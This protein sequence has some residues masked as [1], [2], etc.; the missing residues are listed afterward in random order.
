[1]LCD[2]LLLRQIR[3]FVLCPQDCVQSS[4]FECFFAEPSLGE[5]MRIC[6]ATAKKRDRKTLIFCCQVS[7][8]LLTMYTLTCTG[9]W[10]LKSIP[11]VFCSSRRITRPQLHLDDHEE[12]IEV[13]TAL[14]YSTLFVWSMLVCALLGYRMYSNLMLQLHT[15]AL[16][17]SLG[18]W[19]TAGLKVVFN[20]VEHL[21][22]K[23]YASKLSSLCGLKY[24]TDVSSHDIFDAHARFC[25]LPARLTKP[26]FQLE[27]NS[28]AFA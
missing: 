6:S 5:S 1:M 4:L 26:S 2:R 28:K 18:P 13:G 15:I 22:S 24:A 27:A 17:I 20:N 3:K 9:A 8:C 7:L 12:A 16:I 10:K 25:L 11:G 14:T 23:S 21:M 19:R